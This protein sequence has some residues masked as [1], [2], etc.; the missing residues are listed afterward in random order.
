MFPWHINCRSG[1]VAIN[2]IM[3]PPSLPAGHRLHAFSQGGRLAR[4]REM[5]PGKNA[6]LPEVKMRSLGWALI[7]Y[8]C[9]PYKK[10]KFGHVEGRWHEKTGEKTAVYMSPRR[11]AWRRFLP[12][13][14]QREQSCPHLDF[15]LLSSRTEAIHFCCLSRLWCFVKVAQMH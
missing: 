1:I 3:G 11:E 7:Q 6:C 4:R 8:D 15:G 14:P 10:G 5:P 13:S 12:H 9:C 2:A